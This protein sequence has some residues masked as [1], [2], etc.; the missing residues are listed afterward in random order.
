MVV[1]EAVRVELFPGPDVVDGVIE[2]YHVV[3]LGCTKSAP[4]RVLARS[5]PVTIEEPQ[6]SGLVL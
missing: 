3:V 5:I 1:L 6:T 2:V 4:I